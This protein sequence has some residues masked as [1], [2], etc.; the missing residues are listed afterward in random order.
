MKGYYYKNPGLFLAAILVAAQFLLYVYAD[1]S[2]PF[3]IVT[4]N[5]CECTGSVFNR[6]FLLYPGCPQMKNILNIKNKFGKDIEIE[7]LGMSI[8]L[9][10]KDIE[11]SSDNKDSI[12]FLK[13]INIRIEY[14]NFLTNLFEGPV[15]DGSMLDFKD[16][17]GCSI[18][19]KDKSTMQLRYT[20]TMDE[21]ATDSTEGITAKVDFTVD[22]KE[23]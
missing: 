18:K 16:G 17:A 5:G 21:K 13:Y 7:K 8:S 1:E 20:I 2:Q 10:R 11:L 6:D 12:D 4:T 19:I 23:E 15:Y 3:V 22:L 14:K 9:S